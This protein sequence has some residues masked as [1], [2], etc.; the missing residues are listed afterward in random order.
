MALCPCGISVSSHVLFLSIAF[1]SSV[2]AFT[3]LESR[4]ASSKVV[5]SQSANIAKCT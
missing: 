1:I 5:G 4:F 3:H 2:M